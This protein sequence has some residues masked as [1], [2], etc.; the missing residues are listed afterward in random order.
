MRAIVCILV[1]LIASVVNARQLSVEEKTILLQV[2]KERSLSE[3]ETRLL[4]V[5]RIVENGRPGCELGIGDEIPN[6][7][8]KRHAGNP[9]KSLRLQAEW[10][11]GTIQKRY[12]GSLYAFAKRYCPRNSDVWYNNARCHFWRIDV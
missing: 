12:N 10:A 8:A 1:L 5:I 2:A 6:H 3:E 9:K 7:P 11:A 4:L